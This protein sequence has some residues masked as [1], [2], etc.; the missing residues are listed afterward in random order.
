MENCDIKKE[1]INRIDEHLKKS[2]KEL[3][4]DFFISISDKEKTDYFKIHRVPN[5]WWYIKTS[6]KIDNS[7]AKEIVEY[8]HEKGMRTNETEMKLED[9]VVYLYCYQVSPFTIEVYPFNSKRNEI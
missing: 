7:M 8:Y 9:K 5:H 1:V 4:S 3:Y 2:Q 6:E